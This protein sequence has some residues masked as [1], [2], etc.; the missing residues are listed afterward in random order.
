MEWYSSRLMLMVCR[1][2]EL[3]LATQRNEWMEHDPKFITLT[4]CVHRA[5]VPCMMAGTLIESIGT[6]ANH[7]HKAAFSHGFKHVFGV[8]THIDVVK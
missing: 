5:C 7:L 4:G 3:K 1:A 8:D 2:T 6:Q